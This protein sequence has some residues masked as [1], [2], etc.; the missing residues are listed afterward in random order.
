MRLGEITSQCLP[1]TWRSAEAVAITNTEI[2]LPD[3]I[4]KIRCSTKEMKGSLGVLV[5]TDAQGIIIPQ[6]RD[7]TRKV[8]QRRELEAFETL[9]GVFET[10]KSESVQGT[11]DEELVFVQMEILPRLV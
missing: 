9:Y 8:F 1:I 7:G 5:H 4:A 10:T 3:R 11:Q 6:T 2:V